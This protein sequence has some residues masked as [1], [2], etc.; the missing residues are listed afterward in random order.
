MPL[1]AAV[2]ASL[3]LR[4]DDERNPDFLAAA[5]KLRLGAIRVPEDVGRVLRQRARQRGESLNQL[6]VDE[7]TVA[8]VGRPRIV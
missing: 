6:V 2:E 5:Q 3:H 8:T 1:V 4:Q 7:L